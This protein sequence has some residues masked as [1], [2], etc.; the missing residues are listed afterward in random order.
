VLHDLQ[1][2]GSLTTIMRY[3]SDT[4]DIR[5]ERNERADKLAKKRAEKSVNQDTEKHAS[6]TYLGRLVKEQ[7][8]K[9]K[10]T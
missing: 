2:L 1:G 6:F 3:L 8:R 4:W 5:I 10:L 7:T 9:E